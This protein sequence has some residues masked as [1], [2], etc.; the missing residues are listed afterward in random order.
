[1]KKYKAGDIVTGTVTGIEKYGIFINI[2]DKH[3]GLI[4]I[5][6]ITSSFVRNIHDYVRL[7]ELI[8]AKVI[9]DTNNDHQVKLSLKD[10]E[11]RITEKKN[12]KIE[13]TPLGFATLNKKLD[14][15]IAEKSNEISQN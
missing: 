1:M 4:H 9:E 5:S 3:N 10:I 6:E 14:E 8:Q 12:K 15:W 7:G 2:D 11:Y 13:E